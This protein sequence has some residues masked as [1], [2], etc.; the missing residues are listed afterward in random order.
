M[1]VLHVNAFDGGGGAARAAM[2]LHEGLRRQGIES[3][4]AT[5]KP[6]SG[7]PGVFTPL[8]KRQQLAA[9]AKRQVAMRIAARQ[10]SPSNPIIHSLGF[11]PSGLG[12]W[13][14]ASDV[15]LV[16]LHWVCAETLSL[17][18]IAR[19]EKPIVWTM[20][21]MWPFSG[22]EH[23]DDFDHPGRWKAP[24]VAA[25]RPPGASG[26]DIDAQVWVRKARAWSGRTFYL[27][28]PSRWL[29]GCAEESALMRGQPCTVIPNPLDT[30]AFAPV[31][32]AAAR[33]M[34]GLPEDRKYLLF[35]ALG[36]MSD[37]R[38][39]YDLLIEALQA[40]E[41]NHDGDGVEVLVFGGQNSGEIPGLR[42]KSHFLGSFG[43]E[44]SLRVVYSAADIFVAPSRQD[45]LPNT[46]VEASTCGVPTVAFDIGGMSDIVT[47]GETG[48]LAP[49]F[50]TAA[51]AAGIH[52]MLQ[53]PV[54][55]EKVRTAAEVK[56]SLG[57]TIPAYVALYERVLREG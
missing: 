20:H 21:D 23:Y 25:N 38:K 48:V 19:I 13:I 11:F 17:G 41:R 1:K 54:A 42:L 10:K 2:R 29:A 3:L 44:L 7:G 57:A 53:S 51:L 56:F 50:D 34:L 55:P 43:D 12:R 5:V 8:S 4:F 16:N 39:G 24:Y 35:G 36:A 18:E 14:N 30:E 40:F 15:D 31:D 6:G 46:V 49:A 28:A 22:A 27:V 47:D 32:R 37:M 52:Q 9:L 45:N 33:R 26:P